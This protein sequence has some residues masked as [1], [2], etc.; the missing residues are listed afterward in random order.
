MQK[1]VPFI[2]ACFI[3]LPPINDSFIVEKGQAICPF[4]PE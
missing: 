3:F 4:F 2:L 1:D